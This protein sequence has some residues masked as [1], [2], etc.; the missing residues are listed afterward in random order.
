MDFEGK[1]TYFNDPRFSDITLRLHDKHGQMDFH[2]H[3][4]ILCRESTWFEAKISEKRVSKEANKSA[5]IIDLYGDTPAIFETILRCIYHLGQDYTHYFCC[6][7]DKNP[8]PNL[9]RLVAIIETAEKYGMA[10]LHSQALHAS[11]TAAGVLLRPIKDAKEEDWESR[12]TV[13]T[14]WSL[15]H[16][17]Y[18]G[19][20]EKDSELGMMLARVVLHADLTGTAQFEECGCAF[21]IFAVHVLV[22]AAR[23]KLF[24]SPHE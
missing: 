6:P 19:K 21:P 23:G 4:I 10:P 15:I 5:T 18:K 22:Q 7:T 17:V 11:E 9:V 2:A 20:I 13:H 3:K 12:N 16:Y 24:Q 1:P 8:Y 14:L